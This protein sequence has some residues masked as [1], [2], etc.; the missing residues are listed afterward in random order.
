[1]KAIKGWEEIAECAQPGVMREIVQRVLGLRATFG[2]RAQ[3]IIQ[4]L[5]FN[6][7]F[8]QISGDPDGAAG[9]GYVPG[10]CLIVDSRLQFRWEGSPG[11]WGVMSP[12]IQHSQSNTTRASA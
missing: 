12:A 7:A 4:T 2:D 11:W 6:N 8:R 10:Q 3:I 5:D 1:M 9:F